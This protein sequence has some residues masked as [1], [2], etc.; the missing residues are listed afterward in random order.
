MKKQR[1][2]FRAGPVCLLL[3]L[4][5]LAGC[6]GAL[7]NTAPNNNGKPDENN[8]GKPDDAGEQDGETPEAPAIIGFVI[9]GIEGIIDEEASPRTIRVVMPA[10]T[11]L[12]SL[13]P[14]ITLSD[15][16]A[17]IS[18]ASGAAQDFTRPVGYTLG[19]QGGQESYQAQV[20]CADPDKSGG[21]T[22]NS[23][24]ING[25]PGVIDEAAKTIVVTLDFGTDLRALRPEL[26]VSA[27]AQVSPA[28]GEAQNFANSILIPRKYTVTA[29]NKM[30]DAYK[31]T[32]LTNAQ[33]PF[34]LELTTTLELLPKELSLAKGGNG[35][36]T[37]SA[38]QDY[39]D[40][41]WQVDGSIVDSGN[42]TRTITLRAADYFIGV[43]YLGVTAWQKGIPSYTEQIFTVTP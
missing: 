26:T 42:R 4:L 41:Q 14:V 28:S 29:E 9:G 10:G 7:N 40:Y 30:Q 36:I 11:N 1:K 13:S 32:A 38:T 18:P 34:T 31:V 22:I 20:S 27:G 8:T 2:K 43:H 19:W 6:P 37:A 3:A 33:S 24:T 12:S 25:I 17:H 23:F 39:D 21:R 5:L 15:P 35:S 16:A